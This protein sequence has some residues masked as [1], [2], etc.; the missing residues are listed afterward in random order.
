MKTDDGGQGELFKRLDSITR[1]LSLL[2]MKGSSRRDQ[3][4][5]LAAAKLAPRE[6]AELLGTSPNAVSVEL[7]RIRSSGRKRPTKREG[8]Q[9][10]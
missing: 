8:T 3:I 1:L 2:L 7:N 5:S 6:I 10:S 9:T 4:E